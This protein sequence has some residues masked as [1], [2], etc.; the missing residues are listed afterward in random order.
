MFQVTVPIRNAMSI[1]AKTVYFSYL[2]AFRV[3]VYK[4]RQR[5]FLELH[6]PKNYRDMV[7]NNRL[8]TK[9]PFVRGVGQL[10]SALNARSLKKH[11]PPYPTG[12][13]IWHNMKSFYENVGMEKLPFLPCIPV[14]VDILPSK[15][16]SY[17]LDFSDLS[18][19]SS[20]AANRCRM[21]ASIYYF[22]VGCA[23]SRVGL[24][25]AADDAFDSDSVIPILKF[26]QKVKVSLYRSGGHHFEG[27]FVDFV[28]SVETKFLTGVLGEEEKATTIG[29]YSF[30]DLMDTDRSVDEKSDRNLLFKSIESTLTND[31]NAAMQNIAYSMP[32]E[33]GDYGKGITVCGD[34]F[35]FNWFPPSI[36]QP[37]Y[38]RYRRLLRNLVMLVFAQSSLSSQVM[39]LEQMGWHTQ[40]KSKAFLNQLKGG[41]IGP[42][43]LWPLSIKHY[44]LIQHTFD[45]DEVRRNLYL[46]LRGSIDRSNTI[47]ATVGKIDLMLKELADETAAAGGNVDRFFSTI[48]N[49][50]T[51]LKPG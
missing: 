4:I 51:G 29:R 17:A 26:P 27:T 38:F 23:V 40:I 16:R 15:Q 1:R 36:Q 20:I 47:D 5:N 3:P 10:R 28:D 25:L 6:D 14:V 32:L 22:P 21:S 8:V 31:P 43:L 37:L 12:D 45:T 11:P 39:A 13:V 42:D 7:V 2:H 49:A 9:W 34:R 41:V 50:V 35:G 19:T 18:G 30:M 44:L 33:G 46:S 48:F 24:F